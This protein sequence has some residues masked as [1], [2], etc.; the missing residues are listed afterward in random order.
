MS[1]VLGL[2]LSEFGFIYANK[3]DAMSLMHGSE[4]Y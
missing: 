2:D 1:T 4:Y 3:L